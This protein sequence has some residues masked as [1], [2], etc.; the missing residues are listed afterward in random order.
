MIV[1]SVGGWLAGC[2][3]CCQCRR[4]LLI[5]NISITI[6]INITIFICI[7]VIIIIIII[8]ISRF[9]NQGSAASRWIVFEPCRIAAGDARR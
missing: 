9:F 1:G 3:C 8:I 2:C 7:I 5:I 6:I 4:W